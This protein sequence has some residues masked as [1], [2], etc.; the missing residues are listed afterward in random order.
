MRNKGDQAEGLRRLV[1]CNQPQVIIVVSGKRSVGRTSIS[2]NLAAALGRAGKDVV[3]LDEN[4]TANNTFNQLGLSPPYDLLDAA[5]GRCNSSEVLAHSSGFAL[6]SI[7]RSITVLSK[8]TQG[9]QQ[10]LES[11]LATITAGVDVL[12]VDVTM[13]VGQPSLLTHLPNEV[14]LLI[15]LDS[16]PS[17][18]TESYALIKRLA[19]EHSRSHFSVLF[20][21]S[22]EMESSIALR[23]LSAVAQQHLSARIDSLG[24]I[25]E[26]SI[27]K[28]ASQLR[29]VV[30]EACPTSPS[31]HAY[32]NLAQ[33]IFSRTQKQDDPA[34]T[35]SCMMK[36]L[37]RQLCHSELTRV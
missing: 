11:T 27:L 15:A 20:N 14:Q 12:I 9:E 3:I 2:L 31:A 5:Q 22:S 26:D 6:L 35:I 36:R 30:T 24:W 28:R 18:V 23:N 34:L 17:S 37:R 32:A 1:G 19:V 25:P 29:R 4:H 16:T 8:L 33:K 7:A 21:R 10:R 13:R